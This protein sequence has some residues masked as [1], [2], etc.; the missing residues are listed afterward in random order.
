MIQV[1]SVFWSFLGF[2]GIL[3]FFESFGDILVTCDIDIVQCDNRTIKYEKKIRDPLN[4]I[5]VR[6]HVILSNVTIE[7]SNVRKK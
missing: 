7:P 5:K 1:L 6:S 2:K 4:V 3:I